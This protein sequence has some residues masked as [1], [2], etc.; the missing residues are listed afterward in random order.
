MV[1]TFLIQ[2]RSC[3]E[4]MDVAADITVAVPFKCPMCGTDIAI[5]ETEDFDLPCPAEVVIEEQTAE[6]LRFRLPRF[7]PG[8]DGHKMLRIILMAN[9]IFL[10]PIVGISLVFHSRPGIGW[11]I[12]PIA[13]LL[14]AFVITLKTLRSFMLLEFSSSRMVIRHF[15][16]P[17]GFNFAY[18][19]VPPRNVYLESTKSS[20]NTF[21]C[22]SDIVCVKTR[23]R[24]IRIDASPSPDLARYI[25]HLIRRQLITMG[26]E[27]QDG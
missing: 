16:G 21:F 20:L 13:F 15:L 12:I 26:H 7:L 5:V 19:V 14:L 17:L 25:T 11:M 1:K 22:S 6:R 18:N 23:R 2:C 24:T 4:I 8:T 27:L 9:A 3:A 10:I